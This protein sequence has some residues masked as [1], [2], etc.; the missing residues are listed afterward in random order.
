MLVLEILSLV[1]GSGCHVSDLAG[2]VI[3]LFRSPIFCFVRL[4]WVVVPRKSL[5]KPEDFVTAAL[6]SSLPLESHL[7]DWANAQGHNTEIELWTL[8]QFEGN[9]CICVCCG[10]LLLHIWRVLPSSRT[11]YK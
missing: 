4:L 10:H 2:A 3:L 8:S 6:L 5:G 1:L 7:L 9:S 11:E